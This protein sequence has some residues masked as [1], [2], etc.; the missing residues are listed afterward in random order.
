[1][2]NPIELPAATSAAV[3]G[4]IRAALCAPQFPHLFGAAAFATDAV[5]DGEALFAIGRDEIA[6]PSVHPFSR[7]FD[8]WLQGKPTLTPR[9]LAGD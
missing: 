5:L 4:V 3:A 8:A 2:F 9:E 1:M 7:K 6:D